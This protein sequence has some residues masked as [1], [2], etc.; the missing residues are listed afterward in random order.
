LIGDKEKEQRLAKSV[1]FEHRV[2]IFAQVEV[3]RSRDD[4][5]VTLELLELTEP[6]PE[7]ELIHDPI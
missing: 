7:L 5:V 2:N 1:P 4:A 6:E 3:E